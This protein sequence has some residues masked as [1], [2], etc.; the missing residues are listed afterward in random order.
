MACTG[1]DALIVAV[2]GGVDGAGEGRKEGRW[3]GVGIGV[4]APA[5]GGGRWCHVSLS[6]CPV[7]AGWSDSDG[8][9]ELGGFER[10][11]NHALIVRHVQLHPFGRGWCRRLRTWGKHFLPPRRAETSGSKS[12]SQA[13]TVKTARA[14]ASKS[15]SE[16]QRREAMTRTTPAAR[17]GEM[18]GDMC[19]DMRRCT[20]R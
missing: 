14:Q 17:Y 18:C 7:G 2:G 19:G 3:G 16:P 11:L 1:D 15:A 8:S 13:P 12:A 6:V 9:T 20:G 10:P 5:A 4:L